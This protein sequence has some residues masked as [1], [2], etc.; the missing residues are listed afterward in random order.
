VPFYHNDGH[1]NRSSPARI[2]LIRVHPCRKGFL[3]LP[4]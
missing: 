2:L 1:K 3:L 4:L